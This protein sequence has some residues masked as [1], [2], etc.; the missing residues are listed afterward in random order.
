[1]K[2]VSLISVM[3]IVLIIAACSSS[4]LSTKETS[5]PIR[6]AVLDFAAIG[7]SGAEA[8]K[9]S[10]AVYAK[11]VEIIEKKGMNYTL[12]DQNKFNKILQDV[13]A[14][15]KNADSRNVTLTPGKVL[16]VD[17]IL[18]GSV[19]FVGET[20]SVTARIVDVETG[21]IIHSSDSHQK[22]SFD[23]LIT[24]VIPKLTKELFHKHVSNIA[25]LSI[26]QEK[27]V[28]TTA[29]LDLTAV[30]VSDTEARVFSEKLRSVVVSELNKKG[31]TDLPLERTQMKNVLALFPVKYTEGVNKDSEVDSGTLLGVDRMIIGSVSHVGR[32][33]SLSVRI[34]D[35]EDSKVVKT[36]SRPHAG[37]IDDFLVSVI[38]KAGRELLNSY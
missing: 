27:R 11:T 21:A 28:N 4:Q 26:I 9:L 8:E 38:P 1:M 16:Q 17:R 15:K 12:I 25:D 3:C 6:L 32:T 20:Y 13:E 18:I 30:G 19:G 34:V 2:A 14:Q 24:K 33:Y 37:T 23:K 5:Q 22:K 36:I 31:D 29:I 35:V 10:E 7:V